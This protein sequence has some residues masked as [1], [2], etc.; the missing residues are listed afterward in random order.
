MSKSTTKTSLRSAVVTLIFTPSGEEVLLVRRNLPPFAKCWNGIG[1]KLQ[2]G[3]TA[4]AATIRECQEET[5]FTLPHPRLLATYLYPESAITRCHEL[6][7]TY[8]FVE[9]FPVQDNRE[10]HYEWKPTSFIM[11]AMSPEIAGFSNLN[12]FVKEIF[13]LEGLHKFYPENAKTFHEA[14]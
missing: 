14:N 3:E 7:I 1:G 6:H 2:P 11:D 9:K 13:D 8:D 10:G 5:G 12:Q 4:L